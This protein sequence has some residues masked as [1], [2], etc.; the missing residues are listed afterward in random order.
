[1][2][3][4]KETLFM[5][6]T[7][8]EM[9]GNLNNKEP[10]FQ[11][12][13]EEL[14]LYNERIRLNEGCPLYTLHDGPPYANGDIHLGHALNKILKDFVVRYKNMNGYK[15]VFIPGWDTHGLPIENA[16]QKAGVNRKEKSTYEF[17]ELCEEYAYKQVA[18]QMVGFKRLGVLADYEN[19]YIFFI[20]IF[21]FSFS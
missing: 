8:F 19:P 10:L 13:W 16:L 15:S 14:D 18:R 12:K 5:G 11:K 21:D 1:M 3:D 9:R 4:Y 2:K 6:N 17:R 20:M 7:S